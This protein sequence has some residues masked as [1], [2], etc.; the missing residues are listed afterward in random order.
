MQLLVL[1][2]YRPQACKVHSRDTRDRCLACRQPDAEAYGD[3]AHE[4]SVKR[5]D[6]L[7]ADGDQDGADTWRRITAAVEQLVNTVPPGPP[8]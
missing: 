5:A 6:E 4:Q 3:K 7:A 8:H 2:V 1:N